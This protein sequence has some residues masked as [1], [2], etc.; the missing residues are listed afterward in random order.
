LRTLDGLGMLVSQGVV[1]IRHWF[2]VD[3]EASVMRRTLEELF[4]V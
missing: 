3:V 1:S 4:G 2:G